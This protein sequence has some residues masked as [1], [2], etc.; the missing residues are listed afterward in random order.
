MNEN[1]ELLENEE[2]EWVFAGTESDDEEAE[3]CDCYPG[4]TANTAAMSA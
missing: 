1:L 2:I 4:T 3:K